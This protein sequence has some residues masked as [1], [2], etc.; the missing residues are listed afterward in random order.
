MHAVTFTHQAGKGGKH[1]YDFLTSWDQALA[2]T[3]VIAPGT[4]VD[5]H[6]D[7]PDANTTVEAFEPGSASPA[8]FTANVAACTPPATS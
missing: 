4:L 8:G 5:P 1:A 6:T 3:T 2:A 7:G